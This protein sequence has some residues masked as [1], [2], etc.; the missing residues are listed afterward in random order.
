M[1]ETNKSR[2]KGIKGRE[3]ERGMGFAFIR[4]FLASGPVNVVSPQFLSIRIFPRFL[5]RVH[6]LELRLRAA[7]DLCTDASHH[8]HKPISTHGGQKA[9]TILIPRQ[10][11]I[12]WYVVHLY[13]LNV[14][15]CVNA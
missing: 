12:L 7:Q 15:S 14:V 13:R 9:H 10:Q 8:P 6:G 1:K 11:R 2:K 5:C 4:L 3:R